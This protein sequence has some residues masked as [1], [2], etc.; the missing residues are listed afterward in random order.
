MFVFLPP[1]LLNSSFHFSQT[2]ACFRVSESSS[3][4]YTTQSKERKS[5][6]PINTKID[7]WAKQ[8]TVTVAE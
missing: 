1:Y 7:L 3:F 4:C 2:E 8:T 5:V 6:G